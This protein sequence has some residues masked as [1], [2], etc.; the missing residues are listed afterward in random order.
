MEVLSINL[1]T[2]RTIMYRGKEVST[3]I[4]KQPA[5]G[6]QEVNR[7]GLLNDVQVD[8]RFHGG[9]DQALYVFDHSYYEHWQSEMGLADFEY[10]QFGENLTVKGL[11]DDEV[12]IGDV[13]QVGEIVVQVTHPREPCFKLGVRMED[14]TIVK[15]FHEYGHPGFYLRIKQTGSITSGDQISLLERDANPMTVADVFRVMHLDNEDL[16]GIKKAA[17]LPTLTM[18]WRE[19]L[20]N[21]L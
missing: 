4:Y 3:G 1:A 14:A 5:T 10:G 16:A 6:P 21:R 11:R 8:K 9:P 7:L 15:K 12:H 20:L 17:Y 13:Y 2:P 18:A 19:K